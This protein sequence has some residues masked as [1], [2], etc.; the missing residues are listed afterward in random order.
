MVSGPCKSSRLK[1]KFTQTPHAIHNSKRQTR[2]IVRRQPDDRAQKLR[3]AS[4][5]RI[6]K[7]I[8]AFARRDRSQYWTPKEQKK[9]NDEM[10]AI[11]QILRQA[12]MIRSLHQIRWEQH[13]S[14]RRRLST[15][16]TDIP[17]VARAVARAN[18]DWSIT[19]DI[20]KKFK[21]FCEGPN[22]MIL[23]WG[24]LFA[25]IRSNASSLELFAQESFG[26]KPRDLDKIYDV[27][28]NKEPGSWIVPGEKGPAR[29]SRIEAGETTESTLSEFNRKDPA[30]ELLSKLD[31]L[32]ENIDESVVKVRQVRRRVDHQLQQLVLQKHRLGLQMW[33]GVLSLLGRGKSPDGAPRAD[34]LKEAK[35]KGTAPAWAMEDDN[36]PFDNPLAKSSLGLAVEE[37]KKRK[38]KKDP[39]DEKSDSKRQRKRG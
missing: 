21:D 18:A 34:T 6:Y 3:S 37:V 23:K 8:D 29:R 4:L 14:L 32:Q 36:V 31:V 2:S 39:N 30:L 22:L 27:G 7:E 24:G 11:H 12:R 19:G 13:K 26:I 17:A 10:D 20:Q 5:A 15:F 38:M 1:S 16:Q 35:A 9:S 33:E 28:F 25:M